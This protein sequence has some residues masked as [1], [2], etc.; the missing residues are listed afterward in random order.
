[1]SPSGVFRAVRPSEEAGTGL[2]AACS[3]TSLSASTHRDRHAVAVVAVASGVVVFEASIAADGG[4]YAEALRLA[5]RHAPGRRAFAIE[6]TASATAR[7]ARH[8]RAPGRAGP[9]LLVASRSTP[10]RSSV[11]TARRRRTDPRLIRPER[12]VPRHWVARSTC[13]DAGR[14]MLVGGGKVTLRES[15]PSGRGAVVMVA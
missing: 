14:G 2:A 10:Q 7:P 5:G 6:G 15:P 12:R 1:M 11:R 9:A 4:G 13:N 8:R 3:W